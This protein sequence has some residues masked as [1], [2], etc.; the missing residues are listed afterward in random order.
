MSC[1][2][3]TR[4]SVCGI[5]HA[6]CLAAITCWESSF[7]CRTETYEAEN[8]PPTATTKLKLLRIYSNET[9]RLN[10]TKSAAALD[11]GAQT[12]SSQSD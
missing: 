9:S 5:S 10:Q 7:C 4:L 2:H 3:I 6:H 8:M 11:P 1:R 12:H